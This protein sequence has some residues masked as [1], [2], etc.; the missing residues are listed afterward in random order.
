MRRLTSMTSL[1]ILNLISLSLKIILIS[2]VLDI[3]K[4]TIKQNTIK[5]GCGQLSSLL[6]VEQRMVNTFLSQRFSQIN[7]K[8]IKNRNL[9]LI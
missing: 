9:I 4:T 5:F 8:I 3:F 7:Q 6:F 2:D 1:I